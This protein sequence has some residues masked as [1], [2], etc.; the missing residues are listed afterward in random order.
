MTD[1]ILTFK[2]KP[3]LMTILFCSQLNIHQALQNHNSLK[4]VPRT[5]LD[6]D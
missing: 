6:I 3:I 4:Y 5:R 2:L 1:I